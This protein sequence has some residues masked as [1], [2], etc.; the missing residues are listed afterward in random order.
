MSRT[1]T[2]LDNFVSNGVKL[3]PVHAKSPAF[4]HNHFL[5]RVPVDFISAMSAFI[6]SLFVGFIGDFLWHKCLGLG[7][8]KK[9]FP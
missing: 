7:R 3:A 8:F 4:A 6:I 1:F 5:M 2:P 9:P